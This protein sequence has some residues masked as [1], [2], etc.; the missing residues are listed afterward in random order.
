MSHDNFDTY[1]DDE[2]FDG[3]LS[4]NSNDDVGVSPFSYVNDGEKR[5]KGSNTSDGY[6]PQFSEEEA[7]KREKILLSSHSVNRNEFEPEMGEPSEKDHGDIQSLM[8]AAKMQGNGDDDTE[9]AFRRQGFANRQTLSQQELLP[10]DIHLIDEPDESINRDEEIDLGTGD[11]KIWERLKVASV[12]LGSVAVGIIATLIYTTATAVP[13]PVAQRPETILG[14]GD[15][16]GQAIDGVD[17]S[18]TTSEPSGDNSDSSGDSGDEGNSDSSSSD[19]SRDKGDKKSSGSSKGEVKYEIISE[20]G[21][22]TASISFING[23]GSSESVTGVTLPWSKT[24]DKADA[25]IPHIA[26]NPGQRGTLTC[27]VYKDGEVVAEDTASGENAAV[28]CKAR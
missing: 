17:A 27:K 28:E 5:E 7:A 16:I 15:V 24:I 21:I 13:D 1:D 8:A 10:D 20:G 26:A 11:E 6:A 4:A 23:T 25:I 18:P 3:L 9:E 14:S 2:L 12:V 22:S 19:S